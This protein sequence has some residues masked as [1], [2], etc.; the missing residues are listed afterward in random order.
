MTSI[1]KNFLRNLKKYRQIQ[2]S[3]SEFFWM[4]ISGFMERVAAMR[5]QHIL[6]VFFFY[7]FLLR[8]SSLN[9]PSLHTQNLQ[10]KTL[11]AAVIREKAGSI[12]QHC[13]LLLLGLRNSRVEIF[14]NNKIQSN[15]EGKV[16]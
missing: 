1:W 16:W 4:N 3:C 9:S 2:L 11:K 7:H 15:K 6:A 5:E 12:Y 13:V 14:H 10:G 8:L